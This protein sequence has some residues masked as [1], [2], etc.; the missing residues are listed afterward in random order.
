MASSPIY[1]AVDL[2]AGSGRVMAVR[3]NPSLAQHEI[4][5][6]A[7]AA[8][9]RGNRWHWDLDAIWN[10]IKEGFRLAGER[11]GGEA[12]RGI[13]VDSWGVDYAWIGTGGELLAQPRCYRDPRTDGL[14]DEVCSRLSRE[15]I[16]AETG[17][18]FMPINTLYQLRADMRAGLTNDMRNGCFLM[19]ADFINFRLTGRIACER[20]NASTTQLYNPVTRSWSEVL[21][22]EIGIPLTAFP[23]IV[24]PG[25]VLGN[26]QQEVAS[27]TGLPATIP[28]IAVGSHDTASAVAA[29]PSTGAGFAYL[30]C[31]T[32]GLLGT[33]TRIP[34]LSEEALAF[35]FTNETGVGE[36]FRLL[37]NITGL[38]IIQECRR[39]WGE[40]DGKDSSYEELTEL[41]H[42]AEPGLSFIDPDAEDFR[43]PEDMPAAIREFCRKT[44]Q[45]DPISRG[46]ILRV[47]LESLALKVAVTLDQLECLRGE[48][49]PV[50]HVIGGGVRNDVLM[51]FLSN[52]THRPVIAGPV[53]ATALGNALVQM[54]ASGDL[55][56][57]AS[58]RELVA[59]DL[60]LARFQPEACWNQ[61]RQRLDL[62]LAK[63]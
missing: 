61:R 24:D 11:Y 33:E 60:P 46:E 5:R 35:N 16:F 57:L 34:C 44:G 17:I 62:L 32:W 54:I 58:A 21:A 53:E 55:E 6:F 4:H 1:L 49:L 20:T 37:K 19:I 41:A 7:S 26:L 13:G 40:R 27:E 56:S 59:R 8:I 63:S 29:V 43:H 14:V 9:K 30:S 31:G 39:V 45:R 15:V 12:I 50:L 47:A 52:A 22:K 28:V 48:S 38:W 25:T 36:T 10:E 2:G 23:L 42:R 3:R 18:Q 51:Q